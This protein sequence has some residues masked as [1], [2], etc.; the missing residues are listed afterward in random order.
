[1]VAHKRKPSSHCWS[2]LSSHHWFAAGTAWSAGPKNFQC[3]A[4]TKVSLRSP[5]CPVLHARG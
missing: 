3:R 5:Q 4:S 1:L 2:G